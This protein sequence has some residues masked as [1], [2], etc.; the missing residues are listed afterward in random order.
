MEDAPD[1][2]MKRGA[3]L[4][5]F[6]CGHANLQTRPTTPTP[7]P[8]PDIGTA[9]SDACSPAVPVWEPFGP[10]TTRR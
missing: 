7:C 5:V 10:L 6:A 3:L 9:E 2:W 8:S 4:L 1:R